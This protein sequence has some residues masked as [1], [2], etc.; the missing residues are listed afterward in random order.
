M[1]NGKIDFVIP[2]VD[3]NDPKW[4]KEKNEVL[5]TTDKIDCERYRDWDNLK[6]IF[7]GIEK[8][9]SWVN[10][11]YFITWGHLPEWLNTN[12]EKLVIVNHKD[13]IP[14]KYLPTYSSHVLELNLH[15]IENL[16][17]NFVYFNDDTFII[18]KLNEEDFFINNL[19]RDYA[20]LTSICSEQDFLFPHVLINNMYVINKN[21]NFM[22]IFKKNITNWFNVKYGL[23]Q[24]RTFL[25]LPWKSFTG[26]K[27][28][29][30]PSSFNKKTFFEIW[31]KEYEI[32]D[33]TCSHKTRDFSDVNQYVIKAW[34][35]AKN[36]FVPMSPKL[37]RLYSISDD[38]TEIGNAITK[39]K[40]KLLCLN[41]S[42]SIKNFEATKDSINKM[43][44]DLYPDKSSFER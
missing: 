6:Y 16:S 35:I 11:V 39:K 15:R 42:K 44:N 5:H 12:N 20:I 43:L 21:F 23:G 29:H 30:I 37:G 27:Y 33:N 24:F 8:N 10:K 9:A 17:D 41:D 28:S 18:D 31:D 26:L 40:F 13:Y 14:K 25:L 1:K 2:W 3:G 36:N 4:Q 34:Q 22:D 19:P 32:L 7:R 38:L